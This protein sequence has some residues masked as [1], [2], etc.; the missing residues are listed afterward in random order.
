M[1]GN[2]STLPSGYSPQ[3]AAAPRWRPPRR[4]KSPPCKGG[5]VRPAYPDRTSDLHAPEGMFELSSG[6]PHQPIPFGVRDFI[7]RDPSGG[8]GGGGSRVAK[9]AGRGA[10]PSRRRTSREAEAM[11]KSAAKA[12]RTY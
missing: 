8:Y 12:L 11:A 5:V 1:A 4:P 7:T 9:L 3:T 2:P 10:T 6:R